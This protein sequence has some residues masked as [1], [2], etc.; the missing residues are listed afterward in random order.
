MAISMAGCR[1]DSSIDSSLFTVEVIDGVRH[2]HNRRAQ[3]GDRPGVRLALLG[4]MGRLEAK[5]EKDMLFDPMD[6]ARL[7][8]GDILILERGGSTVKRYDRN[9]GFVSAFGQKGQGPGDFTFP[10]CL[11]LNRERDKL[12][13]AHSRI[14]RF[15]PDGRYEGGFKPQVILDFGSIGA[16]YGTSGMAV[17]SG[18][19]VIL[20]SHPSLWLDLGEEKLL[21]VYDERGKIIRSFGAAERYDEPRLMLNANIVHFA[22]DSEDNI[23]IA[24]AYQNRISKYTPD[25]ELAF[26]ADRP[27][28]YEVK[29]V[30]KVEIFKSGD[31]EAEIP[32][33]SVSS[34]AKGICLDYKNRIWVLTFLKQPNKFLT[35]DE[36]ENW[37][38]CFE[39]EVFD[40]DGILLFKVPFPNVRFDNLSIYDDRMYLIDSQHESCVYE[41]RIVDDD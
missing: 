39:F 41:Y 28:P 1:G 11:R 24:Y 20:A 12:Y 32:W 6:A 2:V 9:H 21:S 14:S 35:F 15:S 36:K 4:K 7:P 29:N 26:T 37:T 8:S 17:L 31:M 27:L 16:Q 5:E 23:Y 30:T 19:R 38:D 25:G 33:P 3:R 13:V 18:S 10:F 22:P 34:V 40:L